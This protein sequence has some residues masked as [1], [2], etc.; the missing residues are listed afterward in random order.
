MI[1]IQL[2]TI[3]AGRHT[4]VVTLYVDAY[5]AEPAVMYDLDGGGYPGCPAVEELCLA[6]VQ[7]YDGRQVPVTWQTWLDSC[8]L[9]WLERHRHVWQAAWHGP[10][11]ED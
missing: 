1:G 11:R 3:T 6:V 10:P 7:S 2:T 9:A 5:P 4:L 8:V